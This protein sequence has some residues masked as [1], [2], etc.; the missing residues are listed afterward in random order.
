[1]FSCTI[2][3]NEQQDVATSDIPGAFMQADMLGNLHV[4]LEGK[5]AE[6][7]SKNDPKSNNKFM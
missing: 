7:F 5:I 1:M 2:D 6:L 4:K 3:A